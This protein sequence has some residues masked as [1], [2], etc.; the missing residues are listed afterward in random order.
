MAK[1]TTAGFASVD[2]FV[3]DVANTTPLVE[4]YLP[5]SSISVGGTP[6]RSSSF[7]EWNFDFDETD[8]TA[9][10]HRLLVAAGFPS[11]IGM[12]IDTSRN[13]WGGPNRPTA[14]STST[15]HNTYVNES[16][17]DKRV[18]RGAWCN[19]LGAGIGELPQATPRATRPRTWTRSSGS[20]PRVSPT[21]PPARSR[22]TRASGSTACATRP[23]CR[24]S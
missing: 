10:M 20:S 4:P 15:N 3:S 9:H 8:F 24:P 21:V 14:A 12:L 18:H 5:D 16:K 23:S 17:V 2:G 11:S 22:T 13:G 6:I 1:S 7:Y 19:P